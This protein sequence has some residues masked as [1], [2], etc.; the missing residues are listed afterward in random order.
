MPWNC[1]KFRQAKHRGLVQ[2]DCFAVNKFAKPIE[3]L[4]HPFN[5]F[6]VSL[7]KGQVSSFVVAWERTVKPLKTKNYGLGPWSAVCCTEAGK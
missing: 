6:F 1:F 3:M 7:S 5:I 4:V 2:P